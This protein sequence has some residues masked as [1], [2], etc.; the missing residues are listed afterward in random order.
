VPFHNQIST[1][2]KPDTDSTK[3]HFLS[4]F[5]IAQ[6]FDRI[7]ES[8]SVKFDVFRKGI[9]ATSPELAKHQLVGFFSPASSH[10]RHRNTQHS[11]S[12]RR[13]SFDQSRALWVCSTFSK[14]R[15]GI[16]GHL[17]DNACF[18]RLKTM[19]WQLFSAFGHSLC[20]QVEQ[21]SRISTCS[22]CSFGKKLDRFWI[23][24]GATN[25]AISHV[26]ENI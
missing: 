20:N 15:H 7:F 19:T 18:A 25:P 21:L 1:M 5:A 24:N 8:I 23:D 10:Q 9:H 3:K 26:D 6:S 13:K 12:D 17:D 16:I 11:S 2:L 4:G 22:R 14:S